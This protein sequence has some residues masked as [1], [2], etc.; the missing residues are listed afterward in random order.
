MKKSY[1]DKRLIEALRTSTISVEIAFDVF[2]NKSTDKIIEYMRLNELL[3]KEVNKD[4]PDMD[5]VENLMGRMSVL[6]NE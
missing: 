1:K 5:K 2:K 6:A 3:A 4:T